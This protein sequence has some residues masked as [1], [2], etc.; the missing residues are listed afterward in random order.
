MG[1]VSL[2]RDQSKS[3]ATVKA[4]TWRVGLSLLLFIFIVVAAFFDQFPS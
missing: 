3:T 4:L 2:I 1:L